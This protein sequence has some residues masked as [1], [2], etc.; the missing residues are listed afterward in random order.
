[1]TL[2][3]LHESKHSARNYLRAA[4]RNLHS[5]LDSHVAP[6]FLQGDA[7]YAQFLTNSAKALWPLEKALIDA[8]VSAIL[9]DW[10]SRTRSDAL[11]LDLS[12]LGLPKPATLQLPP[13]GG[14]AFQFG[15]LYVLEG[16]RLGAEVLWREAS[17]S[18]SRAARAATHYLAH[19]QGMRLWATFLERLEASQH[20]HNDLPQAACGARMTFEVFLDASAADAAE[21]GA[22]ARG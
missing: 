20:V 21:G 10:P 5:E 6:L 12:A 8:G 19:G 3:Q 11:R 15:M 14:A 9:P 1:M 18:L 2:S 13:I 7:G 4:T 22:V 16:S 17:I